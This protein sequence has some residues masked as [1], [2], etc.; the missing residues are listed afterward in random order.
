[1][2]LVID[3]QGAQSKAS[4]NRGVGRYIREIV[5]CL[6]KCSR[7]DIEIF[8]ALN[9]KLNCSAVFEEFEDILDRDHIKV[10]Y[11]YPR[12]PAA[13][14]VNLDETRPEVL[15][16][17]WFFH[18]FN[19]DAIWIPNYLEGYGEENIVTSSGVTRGGERIVSTL[20]DVTPMLYA[21]DYLKGDTRI[22]YWQKMNYV[23]ASDLILTESEFTR[24]EIIKRLRADGEKVHAVPLGYNR[25]VF[26]PDDEYTAPDKKENYFL[27][28]GGDSKYKNLRA[29]IKAYSGLEKEIRDGYRII[30]VGSEPLQ[31]RK[32]L[33]KYASDLGIDPGVLEFPGFV[34]DDEMRKLMQRCA[35]FIFPS[36]AEG[37]GLPPLEAMACG[38]PVIIANATSLPEIVNDPEAVFDPFDPSELTVILRKL[39][40]DRDYTAGLI[41]RGLERKEC[42]SLEKTAQTIKDLLLSLPGKTY[43]DVYSKADLCRDLREILDRSDYLLKADIARSI[44]QN[45]LF[46]KTKNVFVDTSAAVF[47]EYDE[48]IMRVTDDLTAGLSEA[49]D[50]RDDVRIK[51]VYTEPSL[52]GFC[53][54]RCE[55]DRYARIK[56]PRPIDKVDLCDGDILVMPDLF[57]DNAIVKRE[58]LRSLSGRGVRVFTYLQDLA[59]FEADGG[60]SKENREKND[61]FLKAAASFS[62]VIAAS[63]ELL[64]SFKEWCGRQGIKF[65]PYYVTASTV[66]EALNH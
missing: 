10:W 59:L 40:T 17:E 31:N 14:M 23:A 25:A 39:I 32:E 24:A 51:A 9:G 37:F 54:S 13:R 28:A 50:G 55:G 38:A 18:Q 22:W 4:A 65:P 47:K 35:G 19:A 26:Y 34:K 48:D 7:N 27:Y 1:M 46:K 53:Y 63:E 21:E 56:M 36:Y 33:E 30:F 8:L 5:K 57:K 52:P 6:I 61:R 16:K 3:M 44:E 29:L 43:G 20:H 42:F 45:T 66:T 58:Y 2:R 60:Q 49:F 12:I 41:K 15:F 11:Y 62:G 64:Q